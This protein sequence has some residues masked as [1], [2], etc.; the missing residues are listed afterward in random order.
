MLK[1]SSIV[2]KLLSIFAPMAALIIALLIFAGVKQNAT[3]NEAKEVY[4][5]EI[6]EV[7][8]LL[9]TADRD[10]YQAQY[11]C[12]SAYYQG[13]KSGNEEVVKGAVADY[14]ENLQQVKDGS[15]TLKKQ[16]SEN[17]YLYKTYRA[18]GQEDSMEA[19]LQKFD[20]GVS[21]YEGA[22]DPESGKG[23]FTGKYTA[24]GTARDYLNQMEDAMDGYTSYMEKELKKDVRHSILVSSIVIVL[25]S[26]FC[27]VN[28]VFTI[29]YIRKNMK[30]VE[31][32]IQVL[33][34]NDL[35]HEPLV[36]DNKDEFGEL[37]RSSGS[38]QKSLHEI[39]S[40]ISAS[41]DNVAEVGRAIAEMAAASDEQMGNISVAVNDMATTAGQQADDL[42]NLAMNMTHMKELMDQNE[43]ASGSLA[44][45][46]K[47]IDS[48]TGE[49]IE[50]IG[51]LTN[52]NKESMDALN[53][54]F[55]LMSNIS[56]SAASIGEA[57]SLITDIASQTNLLSLNASIEAA[58]AGEA[59]RGFAVVADEIRQL[60]EQSASSAETIQRMLDELL[61]VTAMADKQEE[62]VHKCV[63][64]QNESVAI[65]RDKFNDIVTAI[66][67]INEEIK[68]ITRVNTEVTNDFV[69]IND[70]VS[71]L[72]AASEENAASSQE[73]AAT[74]EDVRHGISDVNTSSQE[75]NEAAA[76]LVE[77]V[78]QFKL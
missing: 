17:E 67:S 22:F 6:G 54:I 5:E 14:K 51:N 73:I 34:G 23:D 28:A 45:A 31:G 64:Q 57:S 33:A 12:D 63:D 43:A 48:V 69:S 38:L 52:V 76:S 24:F 65:T 11:A 15:D 44:D 41:S 66:R 36:M 26:L 27:L 7:T 4:D 46:S 9:I 2:V 62:L 1:N 8:A 70:L 20:A 61:R 32:D 13:Q 37:S 72:S 21:D 60:A 3:L 78:G 71:S 35:S 19:L 40:T 77:I 68:N 58:R 49:G 59:G 16:I 50:A 53:E 18:D 75:V 25:I 10:F 55:V 56:K 74:T 30:Q 29:L 42:T 39:V 47:K